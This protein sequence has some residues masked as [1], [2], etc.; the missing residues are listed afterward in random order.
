MYEPVKK[1][2]TNFK[3]TVFKQ[4]E[5]YTRMRILMIIWKNSSR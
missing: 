5:K 3:Q 4:F 2:P 1:V